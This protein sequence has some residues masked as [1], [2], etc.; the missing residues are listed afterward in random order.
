[1][2]LLS[3]LKPLLRKKEVAEPQNQ[4]TYH[5]NREGYVTEAHRTCPYCGGRKDKFEL[6]CYYSNQNIMWSDYRHTLPQVAVPSL[7]QK[8]SHCGKYYITKVSH[9]LIKDTAD[10]EF[11]DPVSWDY[12]KQSYE[13]Y[14]QLE[15]DDVVDYNHRLRMLGAYNDEFYRSQEPKTP[16]EQDN[17]IF[18]DNMLHLMKYFHDPI[19]KAELYREMRLFDE[20]FKQLDLVDDEGDESKRGYKEIIFNYAKQQYVSP[21]GW[22]ALA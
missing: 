13:A 17:Q 11:V 4:T 10:F 5:E 14:I 2:T 12:F 21:F 16:T 3:R 19:D 6:L 9:V 7:I 22:K 15:K 20:C 18:K 1:M 8:C